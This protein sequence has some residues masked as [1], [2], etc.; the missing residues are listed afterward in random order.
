M[1]NQ[2]DIL[3]PDNPEETTEENTETQYNVA[4]S[5][6][7]PIEER[8]SFFDVLKS[9]KILEFKIASGGVEITNKEQEKMST[10][11]SLETFAKSILEEAEIDTGILPILGQDYIALKRYIVKGNKHIIVTEAS[12]RVIDINIDNNEKTEVPLPYTILFYVFKKESDRFNHIT[13]K[14]FLSPITYA[15]ERTELYQVPFGNLYNDS[16]I[17]WGSQSNVFNRIRSVSGAC[18][19]HLTYISSPYNSDLSFRLKDPSGGPTS[20]LHQILS[21]VDEWKSN[22]EIDFNHLN[23]AG[24]TGSIINQ[25]TNTR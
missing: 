10:R 14:A 12:P 5:D 16:N 20:G 4:E 19:L 3:I 6:V 11:V 22:G 24:D 25:L 7:P 21:R 8:E 1:E 13:S 17:C 18:G 2:P 9:N 15:N 23:R